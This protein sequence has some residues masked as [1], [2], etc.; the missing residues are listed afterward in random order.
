MKELGA[1]AIGAVGVLAV[2]MVLACF[3]AL[4]GAITGWIVGLFFG[5]AITGVLIAFGASPAFTMWELGATLGFVGGFFRS[6]ISID[7]AD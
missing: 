3:G 2:V 1:G 4:M 6:G 7:K 5:E